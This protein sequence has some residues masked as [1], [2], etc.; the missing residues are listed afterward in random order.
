M[1]SKLLKTMVLASSLAFMNCGEDAVTSAMN[2][3]GNFS[4]SSVQEVQPGDES[5]SSTSDVQGSE[6]NQQSGTEISSA[7][8][9]SSAT[10]QNPASSADVVASSSSVADPASSADVA[11]ASSSSEA[12]VASSSSEKA[13]AVSSSSSE[14]KVESSSSEEAKPK[15]VFLAEGKDETKDQM[16]VKYIERTGHDGGGILAYP[17]QLSNDQKHAI[18]V[19]GP[20]GGTEPGAYGGMIRRLASH[21]FVVIALRES[22][23]NASQGKPALDWLAKKNNDPNDPLYQKLDMNVVGCSGHSMGGLE[24]EQMVIQDKRVITAMLNNSGDL[25]HTAMSQVPQGKTIGIVYGEGGMERPN[26]EADYNNPGVKVPAC[27]IKMTGGQG[28]ECQQGECGWG[29]GSGPWGGMAATVAWMRWHL[30]G[31]DFRKADFVG[32]SGRYINGEI[33]GER[34]HWKGTCKNF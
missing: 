11:P 14:K 1:K 19:W 33:I 13:P 4:S 29:H 24:S 16:R 25:G 23:G 34:G 21:G 10:A 30:G 17:E 7:A 27:L 12:K 3:Y 22:P 15:G 26:A 2:N 32:T 8:E 18:V 31:E 20:G 6:L 5:S 9:S 28:N